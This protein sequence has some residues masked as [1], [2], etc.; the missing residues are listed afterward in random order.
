VRSITVKH[1]EYIVLGIKPDGF[2]D[3]ERI[4]ATPTIRVA[5]HPGSVELIAK[6]ASEEVATASIQPPL[7]P[8]LTYSLLEGSNLDQKWSVSRTGV[9]GQQTFLGSVRCGTDTS[10]WSHSRQ[11]KYGQNLTDFPSKELAA[12]SLAN[13]FDREHLPHPLAT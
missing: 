10:R 2:L 11:P 5:L 13:A 9:D 8:A 12:Q 7:Q 6:A 3:C 1:W 4:G